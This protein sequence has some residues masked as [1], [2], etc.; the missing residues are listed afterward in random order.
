MAPRTRRLAQA[1]LTLAVVAFAGRELWSQWS[2]V[3]GQPLPRLALGPLLASCAVVLVTYALLIETWRR[4]LGLWRAPV[5]F[6]EAVRVWSVSNLGKYVP[7]KVWQI[8]AMTVMLRRH[9]VS[10]AAAGGAAVVVT[11]GN[12]VAGFALV[13]LLGSGSLG[14]ALGPGASRA[15]FVSTIAGAA[16]LVA[17]P[18]VATRAAAWAG[19]LQRRVRRGTAPGDG[20]PVAQPAPDVPR[21]APL[22]AL[23]GCALAWLA[24]GVAFQL[25]ARAVLDRPVAGVLRWTVAYT[26]SYLLGYLAL[27]TPGGLGVRELALVA[28]LRALDLASPPEA[29]LLTVASR[30][31]LTVLELVPGLAFLALGRQSAARDHV[32]G[33]A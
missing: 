4:V 9:G 18:F 24:Y 12:V 19:A 25:F 16:A 29:A 2:S 21:L 32:P 15:A 5:P 27:F 33:D 13:L 31:W 3:R 30:L 26:L 8:S 6:G 11:I 14:A 10:T 23:V 20:R 17:A 1:A 7:G 22:V 28:V